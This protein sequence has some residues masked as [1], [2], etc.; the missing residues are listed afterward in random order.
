M[1]HALPPHAAEAIRSVLSAHALSAD[2][3]DACITVPAANATGYSVAIDSGLVVSF[4]DLWHCHAPDLS[5]CLFLF[6]RGLY[7]G[8]RLTL[9]LTNGHTYYSKVHFR[10]PEGAWAPF[11]SVGAFRLPLW[12]RSRVE[13]I[14]EHLSR[15][16]A[17]GGCAAV[18]RTL[19]LPWPADANPNPGA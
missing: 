9:Y 7:S 14:N 11:A 1:E 17:E 12:R 18:H 5:E 15:E 19:G 6:F 10:D 4:G 13:L 3:D 8:T 2:A 16:Q